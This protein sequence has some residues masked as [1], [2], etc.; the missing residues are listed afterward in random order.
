MWPREDL[1]LG[2][3]W[4]ILE[5]RM[6]SLWWQHVGDPGAGAIYT[7]VRENRM[8]LFPTREKSRSSA[9]GCG[10]GGKAVILGDVSEAESTEPGD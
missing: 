4:S 1:K 8:L 10:H 6:L 2:M 9:G 7:A 3:I 5:C